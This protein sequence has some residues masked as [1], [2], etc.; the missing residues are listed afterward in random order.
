MYLLSLNCAHH[1]ALLFKHVVSCVVCV[2]FATYE[3]SKKTTFTFW[4]HKCKAGMLSWYRSLLWAT[5]LHSCFINR[6]GLQIKNFPNREI[7]RFRHRW[8]SMQI[9][10]VDSSVTQ[11]CC[12]TRHTPALDLCTIQSNGLLGIS[13][14]IR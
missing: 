11:R 7:T 13:T 12:G 1:L 14:G 4:S 2:G 3:N 9:L 10:P 5:F 6:P 8:K